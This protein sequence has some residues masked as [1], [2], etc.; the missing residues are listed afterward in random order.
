MIARGSSVNVDMRKVYTTDAIDQFVAYSPRSVN[1]PLAQVR[2]E[3]EEH[4][5]KVL[6]RVLLELDE[7]PSGRTAAGD[8]DRLRGIPAVGVRGGRG[9]IPGTDPLRALLANERRRGR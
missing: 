5:A 8:R 4:Q 7:K 2:R 3:L 6:A 1:I 9:A